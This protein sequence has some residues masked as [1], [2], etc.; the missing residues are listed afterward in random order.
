MRDHKLIEKT[1]LFIHMNGPQMEIVLKLKQSS[2]PAFSFLNFDSSLNQYFRYILSV[3]KSGKYVPTLQVDEVKKVVPEAEKKACDSESEDEDGGYLHP[4]LMGGTIMK[5]VS[6]A[7]SNP[8]PP[9]SNDAKSDVVKKMKADPTSTPTCAMSIS[10]LHLKGQKG[11]TRPSKFSIL[12]PPPQEVQKIIDKL[13]EK[14]AHSGEEFESSIK[15]RTDPRFE[16]LNPGNCFHAHYVRRKLHYIEENQKSVANSKSNEARAT[17]CSTRNISFSFIRSK[18]GNKED[19]RHVSHGRDQESAVHAPLTPAESSGERESVPRE[20][21]LQEER[22]RKAAIFL[23]LL[24][25]REQDA[26]ES[27]TEEKR[28]EDRGKDPSPKH[29]PSLPFA[30]RDERKR[31]ERKRRSRS[32]DRGSKSR[33]RSADRAGRKHG[34]TRRRSRS[35]SP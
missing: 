5:K 28:D 7:E 34:K 15:R 19:G 21:R 18:S 14:V 26:D 20:K 11:E 35:R 33:D 31:S 29:S 8:C 1:A 30:T 4:S 23:S 22:K 2:N 10:Q 17:P 25:S 3:I 27:T 16:F 13:A 24:K 6:V 12:P 32:R 9:Q